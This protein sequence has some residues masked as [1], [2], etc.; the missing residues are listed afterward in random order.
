MYKA[1]A[2]E[3]DVGKEYIEISEKH[4]KWEGWGREEEEKK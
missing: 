4:N 1:V 3:A 2:V